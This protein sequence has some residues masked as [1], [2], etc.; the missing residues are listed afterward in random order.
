MPELENPA[1]RPTIAPYNYVIAGVLLVMGLVFGY[2]MSR[3][4]ASKGKLSMKIGS[5]SVD[6]NVENDLQSMKT[7]MD[8][9]F[10]DENSRREMTALLGEFHKL[11][12]VNDPKIVE[13]I[14]KLSPESPVS[15]GLQN[16]CER[17]KGAFARQLNE[18]RL[19][20]PLNAQF[21][22]D[23]AVVCSGSDFF[24][25][26]I[27]IFDMNEEKSVTLSATRSRPCQLSSPEGSKES[28]Q[29]T[30][31]AAKELFGADRLNSLNMFERGLAGIATN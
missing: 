28:I 2:L 29:I 26:R 24:G 31:G 21:R 11:Y 7:L 6:M 12:P 27:V 30:K 14:S 10:K 9:V 22:D 16:L 25:R 8:K 20:F 13:E 18:I 15:K 19:S 17:Q 23:E 5:A 4:N 3:S 1:A